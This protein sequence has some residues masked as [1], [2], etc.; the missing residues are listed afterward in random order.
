MKLAVNRKRSLRGRLKKIK[1]VLCLIDGVMTDGNFYII[2]GFEHDFART[3]LKHD[4]FG[5]V[6][7]KKAGIEVALI[8]NHD[9][10]MMSHKVEDL[11]ISTV[12]TGSQ[13]H[14]SQAN[15]YRE[16]L[17]IEWD[18]MLFIG[19]DLMEYELMQKVGVSACPSSAT[20]MILEAADIITSARGGK[21]C[22]REVVDTLLEVKEID[23]VAL[24]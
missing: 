23:A 6:L 19:D 13:D 15:R 10:Q 24:C 8:A 16:K 7:A 17:G 9:S 5:V 20:R 11:G 18:E 3:V 1:A 12:I 22:F 2:P 4:S 21:G 14:V